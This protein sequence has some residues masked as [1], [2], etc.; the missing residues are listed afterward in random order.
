[1][2]VALVRAPGP[3]LAEGLV[4]HIERR[5]VDVVRAHGQWEAYVA[6]LGAAGWDTVEVEPA[7]GCPDAVFVEDT[8][9]VCEDVAVVTRPGAPSRRAETDGAEEA[10]RVLGY[11]IARIEE[12]GTLDGG[13]VLAGDGLL[14]V[15]VGGRSNE[16]GA[17]QLGSLLGVRVVTV[18]L[19]AAL[20][21]KT[22]VAR[23]PDGSYAG[24]PP[25]MR[26]PLLF[27]GLRAVPER[28]GANVVQLGGNRVLI[29][30]DCPRTAELLAG[31]GFDPVAVDISE[32]RKLEAGVSCLS[33]LAQR[34]M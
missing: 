16:E 3:R 33:V 17:R 15:G 4:T 22:V 34:L 18:P 19:A 29:A 26:D 20:H 25:L 12:P 9:V 2:N 31:L 1:V 28:S 24:Y 8:L 7:D 27:A 6:A 23:L 32:L 11:R 14:H 30:G 10:A 21:L 5:P 13:D